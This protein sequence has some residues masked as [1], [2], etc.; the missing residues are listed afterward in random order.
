MKIDGQTIKTTSKVPCR[1][2][3]YLFIPEGSNSPEL[4]HVVVYPS[5]FRYGIQWDSYFGV[6]NHRCRNVESYRGQ[7]VKI[8]L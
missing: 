8:E 1:E 5:E 7:F 6:A 4:L 2:G 3:Y